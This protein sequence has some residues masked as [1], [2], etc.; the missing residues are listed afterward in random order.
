MRYSY[1]E[2]YV[3]ESLNDIEIGLDSIG[4]ELHSKTPGA[5]WIYA[6]EGLGY[7]VHAQDDEKTRL[8]DVTIPETHPL[9]NIGVI[10]NCAFTTPEKLFRRIHL[11]GG[12]EFS[13]VGI[14][15]TMLEAEDYDEE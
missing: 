3:G 13:K 11:Y 10:I 9:F 7:K 2:M 6:S 5:Y 1:L 12:K 8:V 15:V 4:A 14:P